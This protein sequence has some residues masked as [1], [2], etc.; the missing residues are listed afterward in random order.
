M[1]DP[2]VIPVD[3]EAIRLLR[4]RR[5]WLH[6]AVGTLLTAGLY[7]AGHW[8]FVE[9]EVEGGLYV[10]A[11]AIGFAI[12][13]AGLLGARRHGVRF[14]GGVVG[15]VVASFGLL[16]SL[17]GVALV[18]LNDFLDIFHGI[19]G[20]PV[21]YDRTPTHIAWLRVIW[22]LIGLAASALL[23]IACLRS[24]RVNRRMRQQH[25]VVAGKR[26]HTLWWTIGT[27]TVAMALMLVIESIVNYEPPRL[28]HGKKESMAVPDTKGQ[29]R[30]DRQLKDEG[31][32]GS[33]APYD[34]GSKKD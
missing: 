14:A 33:K 11:P 10:S 27:T 23:M 12:L 1:S 4:Q 21:Y 2:S 29:T 25:L 19:G 9:K 6:V 26:I 28:D 34:A 30:P 22:Q 17:G 16:L 15:I 7:T 31:K 13:I 8:F 5:W 3:S 24:M 18:I 32:K 20:H